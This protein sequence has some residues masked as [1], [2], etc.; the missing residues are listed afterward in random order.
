[1]R[2]YAILRLLLAAFFLYFA[3]PLIPA[4]K[5]QVE[6]IFWASWLGFLVLVV[7]ANFA[8]LLQL[9]EPPVMEQNYERIRQ[10]DS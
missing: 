1:M 4:A 2:H 8:T 7:G 6:M 5:S 3:W 10:T 9:S